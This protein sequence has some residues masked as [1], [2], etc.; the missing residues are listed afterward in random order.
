MTLPPA[1]FQPIATS[2][3]AAQAFIFVEL[4][5]V[6]SFGDD[7]DQAQDGARAYAEALEATLAG[8]DWSFAS[9]R[10]SLPPVEIENL[11][12]DP[13]LQHVY[14]LPPDCLSVRRVG[15]W[16]LRYRIDAD[17]LLRTT[18]LPPLPIRY[19]ARIWDETKMP[20]SVRLVIALHM[21]G[22]LAPRWLGSQTKRDQLDRQHRA[23][24]AEAR[25]QDADQASQERYDDPFGAWV[26]GALR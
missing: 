21:A 16:E 26:L 3:V 5:P 17:G 6:S 25:R 23:A 15:D 12:A 10:A 2:G 4:G 22:L 19:T 1:P 7:S 24:L 8:T 18:A 11:T 14:A 9:R 13:E 20:A